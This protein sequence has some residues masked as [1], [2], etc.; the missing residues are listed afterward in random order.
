ML[1]FNFYIS[2]RS[3]FADDFFLSFKSAFPYFRFIFFSFAVLYFLKKQDYLIKYF[4]SSL[5]LT[6]VVL[7]IDAI[8]QYV[9]GYN[10]IGYT[11]DNPDKL[12]GLFGSEAVLGSYLI[13]LLPLT[14]VSYFVLFK[15][16]L[17]TSFHLLLIFFI[18]LVIFYQDLDVICIINYISNF[19]FFLFKIL[20]NIYYLGFYF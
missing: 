16:K 11:I 7:C 8:I 18:S 15:N 20:E 3:I 12:N 19:I 1:I 4:S 6:V 17:N 5:V 2:L 10:L 13:R 9:L 14:I